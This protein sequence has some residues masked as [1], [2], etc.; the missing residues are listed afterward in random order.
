MWRRLS[1]MALFSA[2][3]GGCATAGGGCPPLV[4]YSAATQRQAAAELRAL[5]AGSQLAMMTDDYGK[6]RKACRLSVGK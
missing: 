5:P 3:L 2:A 1:T 6:L 4:T